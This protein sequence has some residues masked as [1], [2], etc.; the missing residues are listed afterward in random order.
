[1]SVRELRARIAKLDTEIDLQ[2]ELLKNLERDKSLV[3]RQ[4]NNVLDPVA[5]LPLEISS[6]IFL[7]CLRPFP[8]HGA[9]NVP[10]LFLNICNTWTD[11]A[12]SIP[13]L[14]SAI[15]IAF[16][17]PSGLKELLPIWLGRARNQPLS[18]SF[19][20]GE[21]FDEDIVAIVWRYGQKMK[22]LQLF[23]D[24]SEDERGDTIEDVIPGPLPSLQTLTMRGEVFT[25][26]YILEVLRLAPN[27]IEYVVYNTRILPEPNVEK[28][29]LPNLRRLIFGEPGKRPHR[30]LELLEY[31]SL[32]RLEVLS[33]ETSSHSLLAFLEQS[34][35]PLLELILESRN[36]VIDFVALAGYVPDLIRLE[37]WCPEYVEV[38]TL[39]AALASQSLLPHLRTL[40]LHPHYQYF[41]EHSQAFWTMLAA[42]L[43]A[44]RTQIQVFR[45]MVAYR[46]PDSLMP[47]PDIAAAIR[48]L[49]RDG[50]HVSISATQETWSL[51]D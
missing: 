41:P 43:A 16:P 33:I 21:Q 26:Q 22:H 14:W 32:P 20:V 50:M 45:F 36:G 4:L 28:V 48:E 8:D 17:C 34:S 2:R 38:E 47:G 35:P 3:Q 29:G 40:V 39:F 27:L 13:A 18:V 42:A 46:L 15:N 24:W 11:I 37:V 19:E 51:F 25:L 6:E 9:R 49:R 7:Q 30:D 23:E 5:R 44:R 10:M 31:L 12:L 1:M